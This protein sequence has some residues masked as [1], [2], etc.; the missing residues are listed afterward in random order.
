MADAGPG[1]ERRPPGPDLR[2]GGENAVIGETVEHVEIAEHRGEHRVHHAEP[3]AGEERPL[4]ERLLDRGCIT[5]SEVA[6]LANTLLA[7]DLM[8]R[9]EADL[10]I[11]LDRLVARLDGL[12]GAT[13]NGD[14]TQSSTRTRRHHPDR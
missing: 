1:R 4:A 9:A 3:L 14:S 5:D 12:D 13:A 7:D 10:I 11:A 8:H 6:E 2:S